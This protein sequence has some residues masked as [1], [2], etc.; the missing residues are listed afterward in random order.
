[1]PVLCLE[2]LGIVNEQI[3]CELVITIAHLQ[4]LITVIGA[5]AIRKSP[6]IWRIG[7]CS[8]AISH[9]KERY[10]SCRCEFLDAITLISFGYTQPYKYS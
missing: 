4:V 9:L 8:T 6:A 7:S 2:I 5:D 1:M 10:T 3:V